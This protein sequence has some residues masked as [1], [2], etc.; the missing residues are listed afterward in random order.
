MSCFLITTTIYLVLQ[1]DKHYE[2][3]KLSLTTVLSNIRNRFLVCYG[4]LEDIATR[5]ECGAYD[6]TVAATTTL[7]YYYSTR[8]TSSASIIVVRYLSSILSS[9]FEEPK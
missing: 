6:A 8:T 5:E 3:V 9:T 2:D 4:F 7:L 1:N